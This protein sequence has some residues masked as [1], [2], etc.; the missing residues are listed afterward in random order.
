MAERAM[1]PLDGLVVLDLSCAVAGAY[2]TKLFADAGADVIKIEGRSTPDPLRE[3][4]ASYDDD[5]DRV[6]LFA[7]L[8]T[9]KQSL[10]LDLGDSAGL[11]EFLELAARCDAIIEDRP[12]GELEQLG[13]DPAR[14]TNDYPS[15]V[16]TSIS[17]FGR[18]GP[19]R[20]Y[21]ANDLLVDAIG[22]ALAKR[23]IAPRQPTRL[24]PHATSFLGG[25][26]AAGATLAAISSAQVDGVGD[27]IDLSIV[28]ALLGAPDRGL[29][30][31]PFTQTDTPRLASPRALQNFPC[32]DGFIAIAFNRGIDRIAQAIG[33]PRLATDPR[34][35]TNML[36]LEHA[37]EIEAIVIPW[38]ISRT[39]REAF[40]ILQRHRVISA[41]VSRPD[42]LATDPQ[43]VY[44]RVFQA[45]D[46]AGHELRLPRPPYR[47]A[48]EDPPRL[49]PP[50]A[51]DE[52]DGAWLDRLLAEPAAARRSASRADGTS[53]RSLPLEG[54]RVLDFGDAWA[55]PYAAVLLADAG[56]EVVRVEDVHR[57]PAN[58]RGPRVP[59]PPYNGYRDRDPGERPWE[60]FF[61]YNGCERN[62]YGI[63]LDAKQE[64]GRELFLRLTERSDLVLSNYTRETLKSLGLRYEDLSDRNP[65]LVMLQISGYG[66]DGPY[67]DY[68]AL[69]TTIDAITSHQSLHGYPESTPAETTQGYYADAATAY[70][71]FF[72][73]MAALR[74][75]DR[76]GRGQHLDI[77]LAE[78]MFGPLGGAIGA[79]SIAPQPVFGNRD[80][81]FAP[82]GC[83]PTRARPEE[84]GT[85]RQ[86]DDRWIAIACESEEQWRALAVAIE[87][88]AL[89][90]DP[91][92][93]DAEA[94]HAHHDELDELIGAWTA[95]QDALELMHRLQAD[96]VPAAAVL[97]D[98]DVF[99]DPHLATRGFF[100][101]IP[102]REG[103]FLGPG[104]IWHAERHQPGVRRAANELG[105]HNRLVLQ[106]WFGIDDEEFAALEAANVCGNQYV[107]D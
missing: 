4:A 73:A 16:F 18:T 91:R 20:D 55:A 10:A 106:D 53:E 32:S 39:R 92:F 5:A 72:L 31:W 8:N 30:F 74:E 98:S 21:L 102:H 101:E 70:H 29:M 89:T 3:H 37:G 61:L 90:S 77:A 99:E 59:V 9:S 33:E 7:H 67:A 11:G 88:P 65:D 48:G 36:R 28:E 52:H 46:W 107:L 94:R 83:Y 95:P 1:A 87:R 84:P 24:A 40:E 12:P 54:L 43:C 60:R 35:A 69:G 22:G 80:P 14:L 85:E 71:S 75:R 27:R 66:S 49:S 2:S 23:G 81:R 25:A 82:Q 26:A 103:A 104:P 50:P 78:V 97:P 63:T 41:P 62:K 15:L 56:A 47:S 45:V 96:G 79:A 105:E 100:H 42:D 58:M 44:R 38:T 34:F 64:A 13:V 57:M 17:P 76:T 6:A 19:Y 93:R 86:T 51:L 68:V